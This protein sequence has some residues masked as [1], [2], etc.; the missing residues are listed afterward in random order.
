M[1]GA[2]LQ[3]GQGTVVDHSDDKLFIRL[4]LELTHAVTIKEHQLHQFNHA[5]HIFGCQLLNRTP[6]LN[7]SDYSFIRQMDK[8]SDLR[9]Q[10]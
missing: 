3:G 4:L 10:T 6:E 5:F 7:I 1:A 8:S 9:S 2:A